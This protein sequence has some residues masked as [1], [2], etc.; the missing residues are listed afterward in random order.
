[1]TNL[2][3]ESCHSLIGFLM[4]EYLGFLKLQVIPRFTGTGTCISPVP[5]NQNRGILTSL[6]LATYR[7]AETIFK[8][9]KSKNPRYIATKDCKIQWIYL[10]RL[11]AKPEMY[12]SPTKFEK[13]NINSEK[14]MASVSATCCDA[15][16][17]VQLVLNK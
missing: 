6:F 17:N 5:V 4:P 3:S 11:S 16:N 10:N 8:L 7:G 12:F 9:K 1:M 14:T 2:N 13:T 15:N